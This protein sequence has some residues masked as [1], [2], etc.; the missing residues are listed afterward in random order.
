MEGIVM[1]KQ[2]CIPTSS[3]TPSPLTMHK[4]SQTISKAKPKVRIVHI[5]APEIIKTDVANFRELVQRLTGKPAE[6][7]CKKKPGIPR[8]QDQPTAVTTE[9]EEL[10]S[11][12]GD[13][14][15]RGKVK[16]EEEMW[17]GANSG[18]FLSGFG[19][20]DGFIQELGGLTEL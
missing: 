8:R 6:K 4:D 19:D 9:K 10:R 5:F 3:P 1:K 16:E 15:S 7:G 11:G 17:N 14:G 20:W 13:S 18:G 12:F 2:A